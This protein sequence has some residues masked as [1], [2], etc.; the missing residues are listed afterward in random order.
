ME[1]QKNLLV[2]T[3]YINLKCKNIQQEKNK[4]KKDHH[5]H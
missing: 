2:E 3:E 4:L 5:H 1:K